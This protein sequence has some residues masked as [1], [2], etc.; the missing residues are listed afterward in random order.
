METGVIWRCP[1]N[2]ANACVTYATLPPN[3]QNP[4]SITSLAY[5]QDSTTLYAGTG[6]KSCDT[7]YIY[8]VALG[9]T[10]PTPQ[11]VSPINVGTNSNCTSSLT[12][13]EFGAG[14]LW[15]T[16]SASC[17]TSQGSYTYAGGLLSCGSSGPCS[18]VYYGGKSNSWGVTYDPTDNLIFASQVSHS[19]FSGATGL[20]QV[21]SADSGDVGTPINLQS[22]GDG[23]I[24]DN[25]SQPGFP[26]N[27]LLYAGDYLFIGTGNCDSA[28]CNSLFR[29]AVGGTPGGCVQV[30]LNCD[31]TGSCKGAQSLAYI[32]DVNYPY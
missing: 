19:D 23:F 13:L 3:K 9:E 8:S 17:V 29:C 22:L 21:I 25:L 5:D 20:I 32:A 24:S 16:V 10:N 30:N 4:T 7:N 31:S 27:A 18:A 26:P 14:K 12:D 6:C 1:T 28:S 2:A 11:L 15:A